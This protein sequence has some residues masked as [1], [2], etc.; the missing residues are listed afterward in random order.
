MRV[1][2]TGIDLGNQVLYVVG[3][4]LGVVVVC[5]SVLRARL[6]SAHAQVLPRVVRAVPFTGAGHELGGG[7]MRSTAQFGLH[8]IR[9]ASL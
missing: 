6:R 1:A 3:H 7:L 5:H 9:P 8:Y 2:G 4:D